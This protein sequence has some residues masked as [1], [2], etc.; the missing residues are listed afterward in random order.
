MELGRN[1]PNHAAIVIDGCCPD[2]EQ[3]RLWAE[4]VFKAI[5]VATAISED[6]WSITLFPN[7]ARLNVGQI[8]VLELWP[9]T[10][11]FYSCSPV[12]FE[13]SE[14]IYK[15]MDWKGYRA[16]NADTERWIVNLN[17]LQHIPSQFIEKHLDLVKLAVHSKK[18]SPFRAA[19]SE[20]LVIYLRELLTLSVDEKHIEMPN[21][22]EDHYWLFVIN[23]VSKRNASSRQH[24]ILPEIQPLLDGTEIEFHWPFNSRSKH[25]YERM[26]PGDKAIFWMGD[27]ENP[28]W[29]VLGF[30]YVDRIGK[31]NGHLSH[32]ILRTSFVPAKPL[33]PYP[34]G[35]PA[36]TK[37]T[38]FLYKTF[39][40]GFRPLGKTYKAVQYQDYK[41]AIITI[42][43]LTG[44]Q[45]SIVLDFCI[46]HNGLSGQDNLFA[47]DSF[48][49]S[50]EQTIYIP[51]IHNL[52][53]TEIQR[54][55]SARIGQELFRRG[56][57][58]YWKGRC[59]VTGIE[60]VRLLRASHIKP[61][62]VS[63]NTERLD[64]FNG[65]LLTP[66]LDAAFDKG[67]I[68]FD[69]KGYIMIAHDF[70]KWANSLGITPD[71]Q[72]NISKNHQQYMAYHRENVFEKYPTKSFP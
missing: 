41:W 25:Y 56:V 59:S 63:N 19:H 18:K 38:E 36:V 51:D 46:S 5:K 61:W 66:N 39:G 54:M 1:D 28:A 2:K 45:Y 44:S 35:N 27:G 17:S 42:D 65:L 21:E 67:F 11:V 14:D 50:S 71:I 12:L 55:Q 68:S 16:V 3:Q 22:S 60:F 52:D 31:E 40:S 8:A 43:E 33:T 34:S 57:I 62:N 13:K 20:G 29:G 47:V 48:D 53:R 24:V 58:A 37:E 26:R 69:A 7:G 6:S 30:G 64:Y 23:N 49:I 72:I 9:G 10:A 70:S 4:Y 32:C 15:Q